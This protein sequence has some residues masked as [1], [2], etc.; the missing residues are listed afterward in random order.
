MP[1]RRVSYSSQVLPAAIVSRRS[2]PVPCRR[3][4]A[5]PAEPPSHDRAMM[6]IG[7]PGCVAKAKNV[8]IYPETITHQSNFQ[9]SDRVMKGR[10]IFC[11]C[12]FVRNLLGSHNLN[13]PQRTI[14]TR[15]LR[16][17]A[18]VQ[19]LGF[20]RGNA[21]SGNNLRAA[22]TRLRLSGVVARDIHR[23][24]PAAHPRRFW[25]EVSVVSPR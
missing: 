23:W 4:D 7:H 14:A 21:S 18:Q 19:R 17:Q 3:Q 8:S 15:G 5:P 13:P 9:P 12:L 6:H 2:L 1:E 25:P 11:L 22:F 24:P 10:D 20:F 16:E